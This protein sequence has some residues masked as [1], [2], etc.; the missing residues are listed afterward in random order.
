MQFNKI[1]MVLALAS[2]GTSVFAEGQ[3][4]LY[5]T[6]DGAVAIQKAKGS[7]TT[8]SMEDGIAGGSVWGLTGEED[9]GNG[10][11]VNFTLE[12]GYTMD[13]GA[14]GEEGLAFSKQ[15]T[16]GVTGGF[17][18]LAFGRMGGLSS[19]E[20]SYSIWDASPFGTDY[21]QA[22]LSNFTYSGNILNNTILYATPEFAGFK[23]YAQYSNGIVDDTNKWNKNNH[24]YGLGLTYGVGALNA[25]LIWEHYDNKGSDLLNTEGVKKN[26]GSD[27]ISLSVA[28]DF[29]VIKPFFGYQYGNKLATFGEDYMVDGKGYN[30]N[31][32]TLGAEAPLAG[33]TAK[34]AV[35]YSFGKVKG[36][37]YEF[38]D[39]GDAVLGTQLDQKK[40]D[41]IGIGAA[42][43]Y[44]LSKRT[45]V[46]GWG[47]WMKGGKGLKSDF[48]R[49]DYENWSLGLGLHHDF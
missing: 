13:N 47:A 20:G 1:C 3:V 46:Y 10:Y 26:K 19:Y 37:I 32:F 42:Y 29:E 43:E 5:G 49:A 48:V 41:K 18:E 7:D 35:N 27:V 36:N 11:S 45:F 12:N 16:L 21:L 17:G 14:S 23:A 25:A 39:N 4:T 38:D 2:M 30:Q 33:G 28:Y 24:Y 9:L 22:G 8:V 40:F 6:I 31:T 34:F 44:P 15:A